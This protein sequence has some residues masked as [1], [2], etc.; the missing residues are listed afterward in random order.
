MPSGYGYEL[1]K[2]Y[3]RVIENESLDIITNLEGFLLWFN[4]AVVSFYSELR[5]IVIEVL[6]G[7][8]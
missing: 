6:I 8:C 4:L 2:N 7:I 3:V 1:S 5:I